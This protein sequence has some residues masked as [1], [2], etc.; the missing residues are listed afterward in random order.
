MSKQQV[1]EEVLLKLIL[2]AI[3]P[4]TTG[5]IIKMVQNMIV[6]KLEFITPLIKSPLVRNALHIGFQ[7]Y[8]KE[9][10]MFYFNK[11]IM[12][13]RQDLIP[14][15]KTQKGKIWKNAML[16]NVQKWGKTL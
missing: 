4:W 16:K 8:E 12:I 1:S 10:N 9:I 3:E 7:K 13:Y 14:I 6:P 15:L 11:G 5:E 2:T